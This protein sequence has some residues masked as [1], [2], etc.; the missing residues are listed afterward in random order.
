LVFE[1][2]GVGIE[3]PKKT[4]GNKISSGKKKKGKEETA[5]DQFRCI[6]QEKGNRKEEARR[7]QIKSSVEERGFKL[8]R[9]TLG[10]RCISMQQSRIFIESSR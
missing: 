6:G 5:I 9:L 7:V 3:N 8:P 1:G 2:G 10:G 4:K